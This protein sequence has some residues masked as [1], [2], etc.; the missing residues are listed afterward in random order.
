M[1]QQTIVY[2]KYPA[3]EILSVIT[4]IGESKTTTTFFCEN[5]E[6]NLKLDS[7]RLRTFLKS[8]ECA[9]CGIK[10]EYFLLE[11]QVNNKQNHLPHFN[12]YAVDPVSGPILMTHDHIVSRSNGG[13]NNISNTQTA[14]TLC[15]QA[16]QSDDNL[17]LEEILKRRALIQKNGG[18]WKRNKEVICRD[19]GET[20]RFRRKRQKRCKPCRDKIFEEYKRKLLDFQSDMG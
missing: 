9:F 6:F 11:K 12:L 19:C 13:A 10:G 3:K 14:C 7:L 2:G 15:N 5:L 17:S 4:P 20:F 1:K 8:I 18:S 16:K